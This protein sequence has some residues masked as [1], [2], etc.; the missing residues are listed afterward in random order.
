MKSF[1]IADGAWGAWHCP[2]AKTSGTA[3]RRHVRKHNNTGSGHWPCCWDYLRF[4][5]WL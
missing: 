1:V 3:R 5:L 2:G 4:S